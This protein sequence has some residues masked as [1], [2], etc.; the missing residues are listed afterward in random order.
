MKLTEIMFVIVFNKI[1]L[2]IRNIIILKRYSH[3][4]Y[5]ELSPFEAFAMKSRT[6]IN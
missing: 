4:E 1:I 3:L 2:G 6:F 5:F